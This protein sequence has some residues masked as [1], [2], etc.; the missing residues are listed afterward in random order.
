MRTSPLLFALLL[1]ACGGPSETPT[2]PPPADSTPAAE[3]T[4]EPTPEP[5]ATPEPET[6]PE[7][8]PTPEATPEPTREPWVK[9]MDMGD[10]T[11]TFFGWSA[12][13]RRYAFQN[14]VEAR[15][16]S[17]SARYEVYVVDAAT[18][19]FPDG[20]TLQVAH[21]SPEGG[22]EGCTPPELEPLLEEQRDALFRAQGIVIGNF[23]DPGIVRKQEGGLYSA[24]VGDGSLDFTFVVR[25][26]V[27]D[28]YGPEAEK[29]ASYVLTL[30]PEGEKPRV[31]ESGARRRAWVVTYEVADSPVFVSPD[32]SLAAL[33]VQREHTAFEGIRTS[34]MSNGI[35][36]PESAR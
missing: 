35:T 12:D 34:W 1:V 32:G 36:L 16:A 33:F 25:H 19:S 15:G 23:S 11:F 31:V 7:P 8:E 26:P 20:G 18:D 9:T 13:G 24:P 5:E 2:T 3:V 21:E 28:P 30:H 29:G 17:C 4:P 6:T 27:S 22:P 10:D 14:F